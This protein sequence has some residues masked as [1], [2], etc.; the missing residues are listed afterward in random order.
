M[1]SKSS[2]RAGFSTERSSR[3]VW[4][5]LSAVLLT[6]IALSLD[7]IC[8]PGLINSKIILTSAL[9]FV[10]LTHRTAKIRTVVRQV[11]APRPWR[12]GMFALLHV[13]V[14]AAAWSMSRLGIVATRDALLPVPIAA[15]KYLII[16]PT[17]LL[18][19]VGAWTRFARLYRPELIAAVVAL[20]TLPSRIWAIS[21]PW[22]SS[23]LAHAIFLLS[24]PF[25]SDLRYIQATSPT[26]SGPA[27][28]TTIT[29]ACGGMLIVQLFQLLFGIVVV[30]DWN[31]LNWPRTFV[32]YLA[33]IWV[34]L[35]ANI[36]RIALLV[37]IGNRISA[38]FVVSEHLPASW[39]VVAIALVSYIVFVYPWMLN[40]KHRAGYNSDSAR[41]PMITMDPIT[42]GQ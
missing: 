20:V 25:I 28:D 42:F 40:E 29:L 21:W 2:I 7:Y 39:L 23:V 22:Y 24:A 27:L 30:I 5:A 10:L 11:A 26:L 32:A 17:L 35:L 8:A 4:P 12:I 37:I 18:L 36:F 13:A 41:R 6:T 9:L 1:Y 33:G 19:P 16:L 31:K 3:Q 14:I 15:A 34:L 38:D